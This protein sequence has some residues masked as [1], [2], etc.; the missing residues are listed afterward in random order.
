MF[1]VFQ[2]SVFFVLR[3]NGDDF[4]VDVIAGKWVGGRRFVAVKGIFNALQDGTQIR[5]EVGIFRLAVN[6]ASQY[7][8]AVEKHGDQLVVEGNLAET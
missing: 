4:R 1:E 7:I 6:Q 5:C 8:H 2:K 3:Q